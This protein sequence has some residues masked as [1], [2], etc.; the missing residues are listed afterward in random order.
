[1][2]LTSS[3]FCPIQLN[4]L[5]LDQKYKQIALYVVAVTLI[6]FGL[7]IGLM[8]RKFY[9]VFVFLLGFINTEIILMWMYY[10]YVLDSN[11]PV[12]LMSAVVVCSA[13]VS[14]VVGMLGVNFIKLGAAILSGFGAFVF[15]VYLIMA[16]PIFKR[17]LIY[18]FIIAGFVFP[19]SFAALI[20]F[21]ESLVI[22]TALIG[23]F[24]IARG[25]T[26]FTGYFPDEI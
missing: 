21:N 4:P 18:P 1:M 26:I 17:T 8:G 2:S 15:C 22:S 10:S 9:Y 11:T 3:A 6:A 7:F 14:Y 20:A 13:F 5:T 16:L 25:I 24:C 12:W 23:S 19:G